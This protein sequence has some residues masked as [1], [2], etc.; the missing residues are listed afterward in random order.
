MGTTLRSAM[1]AI[2]LAGCCGAFSICPSLPPSS[3][4]KHMSSRL[5]LN[6]GRAMRAE[7]SDAQPGR[8]E[9]QTRR[10]AVL[11]DL[12][13]LL[14]SEKARVQDELQHLMDEKWRRETEEWGAEQRRPASGAEEDQGEEELLPSGWDSL[15]WSDG[16]RRAMARADE[17]REER[18]MQLDEQGIIGDGTGMGAMRRG[19]QK[20]QSVA[21]DRAGRMR[22]DRRSSVTGLVSLVSAGFLALAAT[23]A[24]RLDANVSSQLQEQLNLVNLVA[25]LQAGVSYFSLLRSVFSDDSDESSLADLAVATG[26][27]GDVEIKL[28]TPME[29]WVAAFAQGGPSPIVDS[30]RAFKA[31]IARLHTAS[32]DGDLHLAKVHFRAANS[33]LASFVRSAALQSPP[34]Q[35]ELNPPQP[36]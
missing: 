29:D 10:E 33:A 9:L 30:L 17:R 1:G 13:G 15:P 2:L 24:W 18:R 7:G 21:G 20:R 22:G 25:D 26:A 34:G 11:Q 5:P 4:C 6:R 32:L 16:Y 19:G 8:D 35:F 27:F 14:D 36:F 12:Q 23:A 28:V 3:A 31:A